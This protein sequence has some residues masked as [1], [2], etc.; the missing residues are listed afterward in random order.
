MPLPAGGNGCHTEKPVSQK[1][2]RPVTLKFDINFCLLNLLET[3]GNWSN[4]R[5]RYGKH[6]GTRKY[7]SCVWA[8]FLK[9]VSKKLGKIHP[10]FLR[11]S[12]RFLFWSRGWKRLIHSSRIEEMF[13]R[14]FAS[15]A[16][17]HVIRGLT[18]LA[19][20]CHCESGHTLLAPCSASRQLDFGV[21]KTSKGICKPY[22]T[23]S[24][25]Q[26][27]LWSCEDCGLRCW[28]PMSIHFNWWVN[29]IVLK[30]GEMRLMGASLG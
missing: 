1:V 14:L 3:G 24:R 28:A 19:P 8:V 15:D 16:H 13:V 5:Q 22:F 11:S 27:P 30:N 12:E 29:Y 7:N 9:L 10:F 2:M 23:I 21:Y 25:F 20:E 18:A 26:P 17:G 4:Y 6:R